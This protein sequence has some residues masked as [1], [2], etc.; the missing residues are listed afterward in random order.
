[1]KK[2]KILLKYANLLSDRS[3]IYILT[4]SIYNWI[5]MILRFGMSYF[6]N[7]YNIQFR[8]ISANSSKFNKGLEFNPLALAK[9]LRVKSLYYQV[10]LQDER[11]KIVKSSFQVYFKDI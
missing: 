2:K 6:K 7:S 5:C 4:K 8:K 1:M 3:L 9:N 11:E 10:T